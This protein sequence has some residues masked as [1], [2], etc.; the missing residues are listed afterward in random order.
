MS[1]RVIST[2]QLSGKRVIDE[3]KGKRIGKVRQFVFHP[4]EKRLIGFTVK[5]PDA[6]LMFKR[7][8]VF[9]ALGGYYAQDG[10]LVVRDIPEATDKEACKALGVSWDKCII[11]VGMPVH[12]VSGSMLGYVDEVEFDEQTGAIA[13]VI[14]EHG[15]ANNAILGKFRIPSNLIKGFRRGQGEPLADTGALTD[16]ENEIVEYGAILVD[17]SAEEL[18]S[19]GGVAAAAGKATAI[20]TDK[21]RKGAKAAKASVETAVEQAKPVAKQ[22]ARKTGEVVDK[23]VFAAGKQLGKATG[24]FSAFKEEFQK[25]SRGEDE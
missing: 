3:R 18:S 19:E 4:T 17:D 8:D 12:T 16:E 20:V 25:A 2:K 7:K 15:V 11:W 14:T 24:M 9:V 13:S 6:A 23:G 21:A 1:D 22:A 10:Q 5:R